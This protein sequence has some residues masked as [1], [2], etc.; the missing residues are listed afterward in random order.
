MVKL[1]NDGTS[2]K[3]GKQILKPEIVNAMWE[4]Q[5]KEHPDFARQGIPAAK[6]EQTNAIPELYPQEGMKMQERALVAWLLT[7]PQA[8][9]HR[10]GV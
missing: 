3:T 2:P 5:I 10:D 7:L 1:L 6:S 4:N 8:T 9:R